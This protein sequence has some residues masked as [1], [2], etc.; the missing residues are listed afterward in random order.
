MVTLW[1]LGMLWDDD[2]P[3]VACTSTNLTHKK[4]FKM[5]RTPTVGTLLFT[6][7]FKHTTAV[8]THNLQSG[9][10]MVHLFE[11]DLTE[12]VSHSVHDLLTATDRFFT[13]TPMAMT[14]THTLVYANTRKGEAAYAITPSLNYTDPHA[15]FRLVNVVSEEVQDFTLLDASAR[16]CFFDVIHDQLILVWSTAA[17]LIIN[18]H[19]RDGLVKF[20]ATPSATTTLSGA[21]RMTPHTGALMGTSLVLTQPLLEDLSSPAVGKL[22]SLKRGDAKW[23]LIE[24]ISSPVLSYGWSCAMSRDQLKLAVGCPSESQYGVVQLYSRSAVGALWVT[25]ASAHPPADVVTAALVNPLRTGI[26]FGASLA[27]VDTQLIAAMDSKFI[28][29]DSG[30]ALEMNGIDFHGMVG[31][32]GTHHYARH[33]TLTLFFAWDIRDNGSGQPLNLVPPQLQTFVVCRND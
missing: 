15:A 22:V 25:G 7:G 9:E 31:P 32:C 4:T 3:E 16:M 19:D 33:T 27:Y 30:T 29:V 23:E 28:M 10:N 21:D 14:G 8:A 24:T 2:A 20:Q 12:T 26:G 5:D 6:T 17:S 1:Q 11:L 18:L 13:G